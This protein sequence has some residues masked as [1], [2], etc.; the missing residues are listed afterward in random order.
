MT[1]NKHHILVIDD[2]E[3]HAKS[4][5]T[6]L[7]KYR[8]TRCALGQAG[9]DAA[10]ADLPDLIVLDH[11]LPD[12]TGEDVLNALRADLATQLLPVIYLTSDGSHQRVRKS[13]TGGAD[14]FLAKPFRP[15][16]LTDAVEAQLRKAYWRMA[17]QL[18]AAAASGADEVQRLAGALK[19]MESRLSEACEERWRA[20]LQ[21][22]ML[23]ASID[24]RLAEKTRELTDANQ[25]LRAY[26]YSVAHELKRPLSGILGYTDLLL[27]GQ[28]AGLDDDSLVMLGRIE[29][30]G[31]RMSEFIDA[32]LDMADAGRNELRREPV[33][34]SAMVADVVQA[35]SPTLR[36]VPA[37][38]V[39]I[40]PGLVAQA[41]PVLLRIALENLVSNAF[42]YT[43]RTARPTI[44][45]GQADGPDGQR[46]FFVRDNGAGFDMGSVDRLFE[47]FQR[48]HAA[49]DFDGLGIGLATVQR[50]IKRH[51]GRIRAQAAVRRGATFYF[52]LE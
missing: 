28:P 46:E 35:L 24:H 48:L 8:T 7:R 39:R 11:Y 50:I 37:A 42:K 16:E 38:E 15:R 31:R 18:G 41:D 4:I 19:S 21:V 22:K 1:K 29:K 20:Q 30:S 12:M 3:A 5:V 2:D 27:A 17:P 6:H 10:R 33:D 32:L 52:T 25:A 13:M 34:L 45:F 23:D 36:G 26:G 49:D 47:P 44:E 9:L 14:D 40:A 51:G 43:A